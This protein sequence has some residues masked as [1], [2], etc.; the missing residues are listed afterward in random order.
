MLWR[1]VTAWNP[2]RFPDGETAEDGALVS[3]MRERWS[4]LV[5]ADAAKYIE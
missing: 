1:T 3:E 2:P 5:N 4:E